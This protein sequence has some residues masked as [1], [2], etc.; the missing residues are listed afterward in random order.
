MSI[1]EKRTIELE[2]KEHILDKVNDEVLTDQNVDDWHF[3][4]FNEDCYIIGHNN[5]EQ[6]LKQ[7]DVSA[8]EAMETVISWEHEVLGEV[9]LKSDDINAEKIVNLYVY[10]LGEELLS[11]IGAESIEELREALND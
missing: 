10:V 9:S 1:T 6:W 2:L 8:F 11:E 4:C 7:H 5:A 3:H